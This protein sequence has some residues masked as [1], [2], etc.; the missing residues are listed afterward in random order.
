MTLAFAP[1]FQDDYSYFVVP[2]GDAADKFK[3]KRNANGVWG[4]HFRRDPKKPGKYHLAIDGER[5]SNNVAEHRK[6]P[7]LHVKLVVSE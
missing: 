3:I 7:I 6:L 4:L 2:A 5:T 1:L